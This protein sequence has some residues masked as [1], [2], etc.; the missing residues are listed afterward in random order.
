MPNYGQANLSFTV[1]GTEMKNYITTLGA[2]DLQ[3]LTEQSDAFGDAWVEN[4]YTGIKRLQP[5]TVGGFY[6]DT[7][8]TGPDV[9]FN[10]VGTTVAIVITWGS[11]KT[12]TFSAIIT[13]Y[14]RTAARGVLTKYE[15]NL[16]PSGSN[17]EA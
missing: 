15:A 13:G 4:L 14:K 2:I 17:V 9:K 7:A 11:T 10:A 12:S 6:D 3:A 8:S 1:G 16:L 5:F